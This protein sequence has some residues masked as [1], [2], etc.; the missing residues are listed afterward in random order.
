MYISATKSTPTCHGRVTRCSS[1][2]WPPRTCW[3]DLCQTTDLVWWYCLLFSTH[4]LIE[5]N[6]S[7]IHGL[8]QVR[9]THQSSFSRR[10]EKSVEEMRRIHKHGTLIL[11][12]LTI[13]YQPCR[14][15]LAPHEKMAFISSRS[16]SFSSSS[17]VY[18]AKQSASGDFELQEL[19]A[20]LTSLT[21]QGIG[22]Q[23][24][25]PTK[26]LELET[27][28]RSVVANKKG[29]G[30]DGESLPQRL[31]NSKWRL[32]FSTEN[33]GTAD[34]PRDASVVLDFAKAAPHVD[35]AL[36][37]GKKTAGLTRLT[38]QCDWTITDSPRGPVM[39]MVYDKITCDAFGL[40]NIGIGLFGLLR[41]RSTYILTLYMDGDLWI[42]GGAAA[43]GT[44]Y[45]N[46]YI[47]EEISN[48]KGK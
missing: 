41:G 32:A 20:Q 6:I 15:F 8:F 44:T 40:S 24:L 17:S 9:R 28:A 3:S 4:R 30:M 37:F 22:T 21:R 18:A 33:A 48:E 38:A 43:D 1:A 31:S 42:D 13:F 34:L 36:E 35:Y 12:A 14:G 7:L 10:P 19:K 26:R 47:R 46:V 27:Y 2:P 11:V 5:H 45:L 29:I 16:P 39:T 25:P 23:S